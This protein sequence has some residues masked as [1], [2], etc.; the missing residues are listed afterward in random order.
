VG[1]VEQEHDNNAKIRTMHR[2]LFG[3]EPSE[4]E[5]RLGERFLETSSLAQYAQALLAT[6]EVIFWP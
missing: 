5:L 3:R 2:R 4:H 6:N 1:R